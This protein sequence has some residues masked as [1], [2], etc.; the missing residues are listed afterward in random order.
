MSSAVQLAGEGGTRAEIKITETNKP[1][2]D[3]KDS[4]LSLLFKNFYAIVTDITIEE[5]A[6]ANAMYAA[7]GHIYMHV[8]G[9]KLGAMILSGIAFDSSCEESS[10]SQTQ[11]ESLLSPA[12]N[13]G[14]IGIIR[15]LNWYRRHRISN[16]KVS[17][18]FKIHMPNQ[19]L[20]AYLS[21]FSSRVMNVAHQIYSFS[22][23]M[24]LIP[25]DVE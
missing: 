20:Y 24:Y 10:E 23:P 2:L 7:D 19:D 8:P 9:D 6:N 13:R 22:L 5:A 15:M 18:P 14:D 3:S 4:D 1:V 25:E 11:Y 21:S 16:P 12:A 17:A